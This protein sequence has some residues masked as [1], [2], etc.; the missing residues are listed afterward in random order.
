MDGVIIVSVIVLAVII[1]TEGICLFSEVN[2]KRKNPQYAVI[3][4][5]FKSDLNLKKRLDDISDTLKSYDRYIFGKILV[6]NFSGSPQQI[7]LVQRF[8]LQNNISEIIHYN[9]LEKKL[10]EMFAI[11]I[12]K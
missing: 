5:I 3:I 12:K 7:E 8:C 1:V 4:P 11:D 9:E 10:S 2:A 6:V